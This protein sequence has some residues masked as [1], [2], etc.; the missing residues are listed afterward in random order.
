[1]LLHS[2]GIFLNFLN[3]GLFHILFEAVHLAH[4][5]ELIKTDS[6]LLESSL[7]MD[8]I[9]RVITL[10]TYVRS[11]IGKAS[12]VDISRV[13]LVQV[14]H[15]EALLGLDSFMS[16]F[17]KVNIAISLLLGSNGSLWSRFS[18]GSGR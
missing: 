6:K 10:F 2:I 4:V 7:L 17:L 13:L 3:L 8:S 1:M 5:K 12:A 16:D 14:A 15:F 9:M 18:R 11:V